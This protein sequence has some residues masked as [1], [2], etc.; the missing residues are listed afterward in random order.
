[1]ITLPED[2]WVMVKDYLFAGKF[3]AICEVRHHA[4]LPYIFAMHN[5]KG[6]DINMNYLFQKQSWVFRYLHVGQVK[7]IIIE[8]ENYMRD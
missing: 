4:A 3:E 1:M 6:L 2:I 5:Y 8:T 7:K